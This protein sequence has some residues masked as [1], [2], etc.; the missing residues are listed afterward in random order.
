[1]NKRYEKSEME[2]TRAKSSTIIYIMLLYISGVLRLSG[3]PCPNWRPCGL[4]G[5]EMRGKDYNWGS[6]VY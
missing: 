2:E 5:W 1:M 4:M 6:E 3:K